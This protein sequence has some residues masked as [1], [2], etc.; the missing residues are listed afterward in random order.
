M[1]K[2][3]LIK[4]GITFIVI[5]VTMKALKKISHAKQYRSLEKEIEENSN[6]I[7]KKMSD[8]SF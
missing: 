6:R 8:V 1:E 4:I 5:G 7:A 2:K 3:N